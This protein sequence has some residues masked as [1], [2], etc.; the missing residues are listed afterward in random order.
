MLRLLF[1]Q[2]RRCLPATLEIAG[3][4]LIGNSQCLWRQRESVCAS[5]SANKYPRAQQSQQDARNRS[6][7]L[8]RVTMRPDAS[9]SSPNEFKLFHQ[10]CKTDSGRG[11]GFQVKGPRAEM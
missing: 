9:K 2:T 5:G 11:P 8:H 3:I 7:A 10:R 4:N 6:S 1:L